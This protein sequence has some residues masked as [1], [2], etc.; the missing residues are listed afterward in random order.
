[1][2]IELGPF[3]KYENVRSNAFWSRAAIDTL[4]SIDSDNIEEYKS[5]LQDCEKNPTVGFLARH[6][7]ITG[8]PMNYPITAKRNMRYLERQPEIDSLRKSIENK[9][10][11]E[12]YPRTRHIRE[13]IIENERVTL[14][15]IEKCRKYTKSDKLKILLKRFKVFK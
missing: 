1:M 3:P 4:L 15:E 5:H 7:Y 6:K 9:I 11:T 10:K 14:D 2:E 12:L 8:K 13:Y